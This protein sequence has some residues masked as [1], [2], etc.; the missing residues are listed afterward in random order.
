M[1]RREF[2][3]YSGTAFLG[4][5]LFGACNKF[6][7]EIEFI[8]PKCNNPVKTE[9]NNNLKPFRIIMNNDGND[10]FQ[11]K[12]TRNFMNE[13]DFLHFR[14][15][16]L[17]E[18]SH[19]DAVFYCTGT[20]HVFSHRTIIGEN[21]TNDFLGSL[22][23]KGTDPLQLVIDKVRNYDKQ[24]FFSLRMNDAHDSTVQ[25]I[26]PIWKKKY[27]RYLMGLS[28][29]EFSFGG[30]RWSAMNYEFEDVR[31]YILS[32]LE[33][34]IH[35]YEVN[36]IELDFF[37]HPVFFKNQMIGDDAT[38]EQLELMNKLLEEISLLIHQNNL[39]LAIRIPDSLTVCYKIGLDVNTWLCNQW[40]DITTLSGYFHLE[41]WSNIKLLKEVFNTQ[42]YACLSRSRL[43]YFDNKTLPEEFWRGEGIMAKDAGADGL[44]TFNVF[45]TGNPL[46]YEMGDINLMQ[47]KG[48]RLVENEGFYHNYWIKNCSRYSQL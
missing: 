2:A 36:G 32:L 47:T 4:S 3:K 13:N 17:L 42:I 40:V 21:F 18:K 24:V 19:V 20:T 7:E 14:T 22:Y 29:E 48:K 37:R 9:S 46:F 27:S 5:F 23:R 15:T 31:I 28:G 39:R 1:D 45:D 44:Y 8:L 33:E 41:P 11:E 12:F 10:G 16:P 34:V 38:I 6:D 26:F 30:N 25:E 43:K 35:N